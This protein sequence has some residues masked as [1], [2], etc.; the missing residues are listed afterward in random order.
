ML[1]ALKRGNLHTHLTS[2]LFDAILRSELPPGE[3]IVNKADL[4]FHQLIW[5]FSGNPFLEKA[6]NVMCPPL[7]ASYLIR[8]V[9]GDTY[10]LAKDYEEH[11]SLIEALKQ[12]KPAAVSHAFAAITEVFRLQDIVNPRA[13]KAQHRPAAGRKRPVTAVP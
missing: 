1:L 8:L 10:D 6:L 3:R 5:K 4:A 2:H 11:A 7:F 13:P 9:S 12:G